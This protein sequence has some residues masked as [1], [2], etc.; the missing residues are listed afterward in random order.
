LAEDDNVG[1]ATNKLLLDLDETAAM[2][3]LKRQTLARMSRRGLI[4]R[5]KLGRLVK[6]PVSLIGPALEKLAEQQA[7]DEA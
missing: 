6:Y 3:G 5:V 2:L 4:P 7:K 1:D